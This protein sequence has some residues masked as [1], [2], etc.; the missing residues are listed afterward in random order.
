MPEPSTKFVEA[1]FGGLDLKSHPQKVAFN[2]AKTLAN[3]SFA[4]DGG[5]KARDGHSG[6][7]T[8]ATL[9]DSGA[10]D[11]TATMIPEKGLMVAGDKLYTESGKS[12]WRWSAAESR[13]LEVAKTALPISRAHKIRN[14]GRGTTYATDV[15]YHSNGYFA[16]HLRNTAIHI[17]DAETYDIRHIELSITTSYLR[18]MQYSST[19][20]LVAVYIDGTTL[21]AA[22]LDITDIDAGWSAGTSLATSLAAQTFDAAVDVHSGT[23]VIAVAYVDSSGDVQVGYITLSGATPS[24]TNGTATTPT[25]AV[26]ALSIDINNAA[27]IIVAT[28]SDAGT[29]SQVARSYSAV[30]TALTSLFTVESSITAG[31]STVIAYSDNSANRAVVIY[32]PDTPGSSYTDYM[33]VGYLNLDSGA[34]INVSYTPSISGVW[35]VG[36]ALVTS[37]SAWDGRVYVLVAAELPGTQGTTQFAYCLSQAYQDGGV[38]TPVAQFI[39]LTSSISSHV[40]GYALVGTSAYWI[41]VVLEGKDGFVTYLRNDL[42]EL[43]FDTDETHNAIEF[44]GVLMIAASIPKIANKGIMINDGL[45]GTMPLIDPPIEA[46]LITDAGAGGSLDT[47]ATYYYAFS[48]EY[49]DRLGRLHRGRPSTVVA[50]TLAAGQNEVDIDLSW[51]STSSTLWA[52]GGPV[53][54]GYSSNNWRLVIWRSEGDPSDIILYRLDVVE[55]TTITY[56]DTT[57]DATIT[58]EE[59]LTQTDAGGGELPNYAPPPT[60]SIAIWR[61]RI[62]CLDSETGRVWPSKQIVDGEWPGFH[63]GLS[64]KTDIHTRLPKWISTMDERLIVWWDDAIG[65]MVGTAGDD[66][67]NPG[68]LREP[69]LIPQRGIGLGKIKSLVKTPLGFMFASPRNGIYLLD[70]GLQLTRIGRDIATYDS[71][72]FTSAVYV[73]SANEVRWTTGTSPDALVIAYELEKQL[74]HSYQLNGSTDPVAAA[75]W[76]GAHV[77]ADANASVWKQVSGATSDPGLPSVPGAAQWR[78]GW[79]T[80]GSPQSELNVR[81]VYLLGKFP[82]SATLKVYADHSDSAAQTFSTWGDNSSDQQIEFPLTS[83]KMRAFS[84]EVTGFSELLSARVEVEAGGATYKRDLVRAS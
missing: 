57:S 61:N 69:V 16:V 70:P 13:W 50:H 40:S 41:G 22:T 59:V 48:Y 24:L 66:V 84:L 5:L 82:T 62:V 78:T 74:W 49:V 56:T 26:S 10:V 83:R 58:D 8:N 17:I 7:S 31:R 80:T 3:V 75:F 55:P 43:S 25:G 6:L 28:W 63:L 81:N 52:S 79:L 33:H 14:A 21:Y 64:V 11:D 68:T 37:R 76:D 36:R 35:V 27:A 72:D 1:E 65:V 29:N 34:L 47:A 4:E 9:Y 15:A 44:D 23:G 30:A 20:Y 19:D 71:Y 45:I 67:G 38:M 73:D 53:Q 32:G 18:L 54:P 39:Q 12:L 60:K 42:L 2:R 77:I 46:S 51:M